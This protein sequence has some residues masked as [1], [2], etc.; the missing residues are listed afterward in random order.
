MGTDNFIWIDNGGNP[1]PTDYSKTGVKISA[2]PHGINAY[3]SYTAF[4]SLAAFNLDKNHL[5]FLKDVCG[6]SYSEARDAIHNEMH[7]QAV[8][9]TA[10]RD[11]GNT[12]RIKVF[13]ADRS[14][15]EF[16]KTRFPQATLTKLDIK[17][18]GDKKPDKGGRPAIHMSAADTQ[19]IDKAR[20]FVSTRN[21]DDNRANR[22]IQNWH[23]I[24]KTDKAGNRGFFM[25]GWEL[26]CSGYDPMEV[27]MILDREAQQAIRP[28]KRRGNI[29]S[30]INNISRF[31]AKRGLAA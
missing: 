5:E 22:A 30:I 17:L 4:V 11:P 8:C 12:S 21:R 18:A 25:L 23:S 16:L 24:C 15:A 1:N 27:E 14:T 10:I 20:S 7:Y 26:I 29:K 6:I 3:K 13:V 19:N 28:A 31:R 9:R 2:Y